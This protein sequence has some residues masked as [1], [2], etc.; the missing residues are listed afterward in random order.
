M[1]M[2]DLIDWN[3][4]RANPKVFVGFSDITTLHLRIAREVNMVSIHGPVVTTIGGG[5]EEAARDSFWRLIESTEPYGCLPVEANL[6]NCLVPGKSVGR[7]AGGCIE[8]IA[9]AIGTKEQPNFDGCIVALEDVGERAYQV[10]RQLVQIK[11]A[12]VFD[13]VVGFVLGTVT[14]WDKDEAGPIRIDLDDVWREHIARLGKP[15]VAGFPIGHIQSPLSLP[16]GS[17]AEL[18]SDQKSLT[19]LE[20]AVQ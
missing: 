13:N 4:V 6:V 3:V 11:R 2:C 14:D 9:D 17:L 10:D 1:R 16:I 15:T 8:L 12:G 18:N 19:V 7:L 20:P 5:L